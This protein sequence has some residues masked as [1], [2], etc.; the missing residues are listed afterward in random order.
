[1]LF[2]ILT[3]SMQQKGAL[4]AHTGVHESLPRQLQK[5]DRPDNAHSHS[6]APSQ[7]DSL[8]PAHHNQEPG[9]LQAFPPQLAVAFHPQIASIYSKEGQEAHSRG[10]ELND[11]ENPFQSMPIYVSM[12]SV[13]L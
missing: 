8:R 6:S 12:T 11:L 4:G 13:M 10:L 1:M 3:L 9:E 2:A 7:Q 5:G